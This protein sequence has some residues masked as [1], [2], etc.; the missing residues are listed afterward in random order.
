MHRHE[1]GRL[2]F[3]RQQNQ[4]WICSATNNGP[5]KLVPVFVCRRELAERNRRKT[6]MTTLSQRGLLRHTP[7][8][9]KTRPKQAQLVCLCLESSLNCCL[10]A[11]LTCPRCFQM[12][13]ARSLPVLLCQPA[14]GQRDSETQA[15][16]VSQ[17]GWRQKLGIF[18]QSD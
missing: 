3:K 4:H 14:V 5:V 1:A 16:A 8:K 12:P 2:K 10:A 9:T 11:S 7:R 13:H 18:T 6:R 17:G 15:E